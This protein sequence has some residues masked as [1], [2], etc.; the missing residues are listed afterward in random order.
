M[1]D[2]ASLAHAHLKK[3]FVS[4]ALHAGMALLSKNLRVGFP[5]E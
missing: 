4:V 1:Y 3:V 2:L 5:V